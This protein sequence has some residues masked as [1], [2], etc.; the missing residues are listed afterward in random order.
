VRNEKER[1]DL[2]AESLKHSDAFSTTS[3]GFLQVSS[4]LV[5]HDG[6]M[7]RH[8]DTEPVLIAPD[9]STKYLASTLEWFGVQ[10]ARG[11]RVGHLQNQPTNEGATP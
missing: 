4:D 10:V 2:S 9:G 5:V 3:P 1:S 6:G 8:A 7:Q 11:V